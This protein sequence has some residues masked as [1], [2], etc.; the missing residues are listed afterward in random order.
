MHSFWHWNLM[1]VVPTEAGLVTVQH[2]PETGFLTGAYWCCFC[3]IG[4]GLVPLGLS[5]CHWDW[6]GAVLG[7]GWCCA[8]AGLVLY[9]DWVGAVLWQVWGWVG[10]TGAGLV[11]LGLD[12]CH[13]C[14]TGA[15]LVPLRLGWCCTGAGL[16]P[17]G[18]GW[19][20]WCC[21]RAGLVLFWDWVGA[22]LV[23]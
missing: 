3:D 1:R 5:W 2:C 13:W 22:G 6:V 15:G 18:L 8:G 23:L 17:L 20:H 11:P 14:C 12:W 21:V 10:V 16:V 7:L 9:W 19:C 4:D